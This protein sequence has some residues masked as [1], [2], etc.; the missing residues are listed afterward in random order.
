MERIFIHLGTHK[1]GTTSFQRFMLERREWLRRAGIE[2]YIE[3]REGAEDANCYRLVH[4]VLRAEA[5]TMSRYIGAVAPPHEA[6]LAALACHVQEFLA[7]A[8]AAGRSVLFS[9]EA[10]SFLRNA[11]EL[12]ALRRVL[13]AEVGRIV[14]LVVFREDAAWRRSW[15]AGIA[16]HP[17]AGP[18]MADADFPLLGDWWFDKQAIRAFWAQLG[19]VRAIEYEAAMERDGD[20]IPALL[21]AM[22]LDCP[23]DL[24]FRLNVSPVTNPVADPIA[25]GGAVGNRA[26][27]KS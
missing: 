17:V 1:T 24:N 5:M 21:G 19:P 20:V 22:G 18:R 8:R 23:G 14:P 11:A 4:D 15:V 7:R 13:G 25:G 2:P 6:R 3:T 16:R 27:E 12:G 26:P 10:F 9:A